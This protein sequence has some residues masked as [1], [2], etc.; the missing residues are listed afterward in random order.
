MKKDTDK[1]RESRRSFLRFAGVGTLA[2]GAAVVTAEP[3]A[4]VEAEAEGTSGYRETA[5]VKTYYKLARF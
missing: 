4:A 3:A 1:A 5:H 2:A